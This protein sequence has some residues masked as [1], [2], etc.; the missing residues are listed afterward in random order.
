MPLPLIPTEPQELA[1]SLTPPVLPPDVRIFC[2]KRGIGGYLEH[3]IALAQRSF[4]AV[5]SLVAEMEQDPETGDEWVVVRIAVPLSEE[6][7]AEA[8]KHYSAEWVA[9]VPWPERHLICLSCQIL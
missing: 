3:A 5:E 4:S 9:T 2:D 7:V 6:E 8:R 1:V